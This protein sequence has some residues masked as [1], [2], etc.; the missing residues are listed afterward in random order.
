MEYLIKN[1]APRC[2]QEIKDDLHKIRGLLDFSF[3]ESGQ[4]KGQGGKICSIINKS[5]S[6]WSCEVNSRVAEWHVEASRGE[7]IRQKDTW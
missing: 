4:D 5:I 2:I 3:N 1:G 7:R 6:S